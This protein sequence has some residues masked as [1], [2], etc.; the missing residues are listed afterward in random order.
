MRQLRAYDPV[1]V[2]GFALTGMLAASYLAGLGSGSTQVISCWFVV[3]L[4]QT[5][6]AVFALRV[7]RL[8]ER[9]ALARRFWTTF[10]IAG[11]AYAI[12]DVS[13]LVHALVD[14]A[15]T[16]VLAGTGTVRTISL[17]LGTAA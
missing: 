7:A 9:G 12:G 16:D 15:A 17:V 8:T 2:G 10:G 3:A 6:M 11:V 14:P 5:A 1:L 4:F 13:Q